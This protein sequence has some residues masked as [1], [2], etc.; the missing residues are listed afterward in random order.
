MK[1]LILL[2]LATLIPTLVFAS[3]LDLASTQAKIKDLSSDE[4]VV[5]AGGTITT[6]AINFQ[7]VIYPG[8][9]KLDIQKYMDMFTKNFNITT[10]TQEFMV[11]AHL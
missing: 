9:K 8:M 5:S 3:P 6:S 2:L 1:N 4:I 10:V 11:R 7:T